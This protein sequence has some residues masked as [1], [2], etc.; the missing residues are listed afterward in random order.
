MAGGSVSV[1]AIERAAEILGSF[2]FEE[3]ALSLAEICAKIDLPKTTVFRILKTMED[4]N[5]IRFDSTTGNYSLGYQMIKF[6]A[7]AQESNTLSANA[8]GIMEE[9]SQATEQ[10]CNLYVRDGFDRLCIDQ[11]V[12]TKYIRRY[13]YLG[14]RH[15]LYCGAGKILLAYEDKEF[16]D[17]YLASVPLERITDRTITDPEVLRAELDQIR[18]DGY[19]YS[20]GERD[21]ETA[22]I[23][24][25]V[26]DYT[27]KIVATMTISGPIFF[28][29]KEN[30]REYV[31]RVKSA[32]ER[33]SRKLGYQ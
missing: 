19:S 18:K 11:V 6:G 14:A 8:H 4:T 13:S 29:D 20:I 26:F 12:G 25:P 7:I 2:T 10:T 28:F 21:V 5:I 31:I 23:A 16:Q 30:I 22:M 24:A 15:P 3:P 27:G 33:V 1:R 9:L 17:Q 32:A